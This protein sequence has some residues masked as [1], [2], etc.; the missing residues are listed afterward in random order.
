M[1]IALYPAP[2]FLQT[3]EVLWV[4]KHNQLG[5]KKKIYSVLFFDFVFE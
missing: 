3:K 1:L 4:T 2:P 5:G